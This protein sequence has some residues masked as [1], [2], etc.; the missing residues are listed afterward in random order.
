MLPAVCAGH[1]IWIKI[2]LVRADK[3][4]RRTPD[5]FSVARLELFSVQKQNARYQAIGLNPTNLARIASLCWLEP[6]TLEGE[7]QG[8][9]NLTRA[10]DG[11][12]YDTQST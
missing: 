9:L 7:A 11:F 1:S 2:T 3:S 6:Y 12:V 10:P 4:E 8:H 5:G